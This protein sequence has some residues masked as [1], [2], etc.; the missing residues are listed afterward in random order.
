MT[1]KSG[2][3]FPMLFGFLITTNLFSQQ[4]E[5]LS[6]IK[7][8]DIETVKALIDEGADIN[9][10]DEETGYTALM[11]ACEFNYADMAKMLVEEGADINIRAKDGST[12]L[13]R[14][15]GN[16]PDMVELLLLEG[17]DIKAAPEDGIGVMLQAVFGFLYKGFPIETINILLDHGADVNETVASLEGIAGF[18]PLM[19][20]VR[21]N[22]E[23][24]AKLL[25]KR[26]AN[27]NTIAKNGKTPLALASEE[28]Y[29]AMAELLKANG[30][31]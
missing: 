17:A 13:V 6:K 4:V 16:A 5:L 29:T 27:V 24:L 14:A 23:E 12:A 28:G 30:G 19:F 10:Q 31:K 20:A 11:W 3:L 21:D 7:Y 26:G 9:I 1:Q 8:N 25:I 2:I 15:A 18:T 22:N